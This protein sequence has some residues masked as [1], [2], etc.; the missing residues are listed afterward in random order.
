MTSP[1]GP[2]WYEM[3]LLF[4]PETPE[5]EQKQFMERLRELIEK[6]GGTLKE[7]ETWGKRALSYPMEH[8]TE[9]I[10][11]LVYFYVDRGATPEIDRFC[12]LDR[13]ILRHKIFRREIPLK[14]E[15]PQEVQE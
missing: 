8:R 2:Q 5:E 12:R 6:H 1:W 14:E 13:R 4:F 15:T 9:A 7:V 3:M 10:Y 11:V